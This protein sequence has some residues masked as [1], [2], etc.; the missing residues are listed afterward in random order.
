MWLRTAVLYRLRLNCLHMSTA[1]QTFL[2]KIRNVLGVIKGVQTDKPLFV[3]SS[4]GGQYVN[5]SQIAH[6]GSIVSTIS[7]IKRRTAV[8]CAIALGT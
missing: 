2:T 4:S 3:H 1:M 5:E 8:L 7:G 6:F